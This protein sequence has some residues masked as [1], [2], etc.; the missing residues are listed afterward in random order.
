MQ[1]S[2]DSSGVG[3][4]GGFS[5]VST[6]M[7]SVRFVWSLRLICALALGISVYLAWTAFMMGNVYGCSGGD[8]I[9][10]EH[11]LTSHWSKVV[12]VPVSVPAAGL[13]ASLIAL[14]AF[15]RQ[16]GP[17]RLRQLV[18]GGMTLGSLMAGLAALWFVGLQVSEMKFCPYCLLVHTCGLILACTMLMSPLCPSSLKLKSA[19]ISLMGV[20]TLVVVQGATPKPDMFETVRYDEIPTSVEGAYSTNDVTELEV[21]EAPGEVFEAPGEAFAPPVGAFE[22]P[23]F[24]DAA[25]ASD[26]IGTNDSANLKSSESSE[27]TT[28]DG[29]PSVASTL[30]LIVPPRLL[31]SCELFL[32][33]PESDEASAE[34]TASTTSEANE[35]GTTAAS[36]VS[37]ENATKEK[38]E[39][40]DNGD[41]EKAVSE[42]PKPAER[43]LLTFA[44]NRFTLDVKQWPLLGRTDAKFVF[45][46]MFD[47][48]CPHCRNTHQ[49]ILGA[50]KQYGDDLAIFALPVPLE[51]A[52]NPAAAGAGHPG[53]CEMAKIAV[54]VWRLSPQKFQ[55]FHDWMFQGH[56]TVSTARQFAESLVG[57]VPL[58]TEL[59]SAVP[60]QYI[61]RHVSLYQRV[62]SGQVP[63]LI[64]P[65]TTMQGE[66]NSP[67]TLCNAIER[68]LAV[69]KK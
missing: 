25:A 34:P 45:V 7:P 10:C 40:S 56:R 8:L 54:A 21:F 11:I 38:T 32:T 26:P 65:A 15:A 44:G 62:G 19:G 49:A 23:T 39:S 14:L 67:T 52:C 3:T 35:S 64:F 41:N 29:Q 9:D 55:T 57:K 50:Q 6:E 27:T 68:E 63:K 48:T 12:G 5:G 1:P 53:A 60:G 69:V 22:A 30:L 37:D 66:V 36:A 42:V 61:S 58:Q 20:A 4:P 24:G 46:E 18:W 51:N 17:E 47:Y 33:L 59:S 43:R 28:K 2:F 13:Y 31:Q 16:R